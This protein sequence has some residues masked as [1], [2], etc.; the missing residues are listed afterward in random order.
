MEPSQLVA[1][2]MFDAIAEPD[3]LL[4]LVMANAMSPRLWRLGRKVAAA[5]DPLEAARRVVDTSFTH[6]LPDR[7]AEVSGVLDL[8]AERG[9]LGAAVIDQAIADINHGWDDRRRAGLLAPDDDLQESIAAGRFPAYAYANVDVINAARRTTSGG[10]QR[11]RG[12]T[13]CLDEAGLFAALVMT[14]PA[15]TAALDGI[16]ILASSLH[17]T[18]FGW[19]GGQPW[20]FWSKRNLYTRE[21]FREKVIHQ[22]GGDPGAAVT[23]VMA[24]PFR[25]LISRR[26][27]VDFRTGVSSL[28]PEE[29]ERTLAMIVDFFGHLPHGFEAS[30]GDLQFVA[31]SPHDI[32]FDE[33]VRC[34]SAAEVQQVV[35]SHVTAAGGTV[36][37]ATQALLAFRSLEVDDLMPYLAAARRGPLVTARAAGLRSVDDALALAGGPADA[38]ALGDPSRLALPD[39]VLGRGCC[40]P[41]ERGLLLHV[42]LENLGCAPVHTELIDGDAITRT[43]DFSVRASDLA[44]LPG[45]AAPVEGSAFAHG[46]APGPGQL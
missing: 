8:D 23:S 25:R 32:L 36:S 22:H 39:E 18:V 11:P 7:V 44:R 41:A 20:W 12:L 28:P 40:S 1:P 17:Y 2:N 4:P 46:A 37:A 27:H 29:I 19:T 15:L 5:P 6:A 21:L 34:A 33:A 16:A 3:V 24:A 45:A 10:A 43:P 38:P 31:P 9:R 35:R 30:P 42:L 13:S 14:A 26:G